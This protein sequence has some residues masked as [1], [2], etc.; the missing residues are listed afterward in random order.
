MFST[1]A[2]TWTAMTTGEREKR[3]PVTPRTTMAAMT[4]SSGKGDVIT[5]A[6]FMESLPLMADRNLKPQ[7]A[8][9]RA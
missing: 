4:M 2:A 8:E 5:R 6:S 7:V 1:T 3:L 9:C